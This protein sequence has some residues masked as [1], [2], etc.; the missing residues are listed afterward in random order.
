MNKELQD[1]L[2]FCRLSG[3]QNYYE[4]ILSQAQKSDMSYEQF[5]LTLLDHEVAT[6]EENR[7]QRLLK[8]AKFTS[9][10]TIDKF[11]FNETP[12]LSKKEIFALFNCDFIDQKTNLL[13]IGPPGTGK[14]HI[15]LSL[16]VKACQLGKSVAFFSAASL[17]NQLCEMADEQQLSK[18]LKKLKKVNF[19]IIDELG[20]VELS[21][22]VTQLLFQVF[23]EKYEKG[24]VCITTNLEFSNWPSIFHDEKMTA[25]I[26]DRLVQN[27]KIIT[28]NGESYRYKKKKNS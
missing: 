27:S 3:M 1:K 24:S 18:F 21:N 10:K 11:N 4:E 14:T 25:A 22:R 15:A 17:G 9:I 5:F 2:K 6:R 20:Y 16:G 12:F 13:F 23:S 19:L 26:L 8:Q 7:F 28:F